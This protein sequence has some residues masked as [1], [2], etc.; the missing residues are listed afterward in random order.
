MKGTIKTIATLAVIGAA[1]YFTNPS[2]EDFG[3]YYERKLVAESQ[4][5]T[6]DP[7]KKIAK[8]L[9]QTG[10]DLAIKDGAKRQDKLLFSVFTCLAKKPFSKSTFMVVCFNIELCDIIIH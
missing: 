2:M 4:Q 6:A 5:G 7:L 9:A 8:A 10:A 3:R 1:L